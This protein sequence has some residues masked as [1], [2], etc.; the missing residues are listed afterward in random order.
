MNIVIVCVCVQC[1]CVFRG[2]FSLVSVRVC[3]CVLG[4][5]GFLSLCPGS[6]SVQ[7]YP[8]LYQT[9]LSLPD[10]DETDCFGGMFGN[11]LTKYFLGYDIMSVRVCV[12]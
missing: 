10:P 1:V 4:G 8:T 2:S 3:V 5:G 11:T 7:L 6:L 12:C 9:H